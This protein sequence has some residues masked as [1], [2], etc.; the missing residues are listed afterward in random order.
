[1]AGGEFA[2]G[3]P[4]RTRKNRGPPPG[5]SLANARRSRQV[6]R[7]DVAEREGNEGYPNGRSTH[8]NARSRRQWRKQRHCVRYG[9][10]TDETHESRLGANRGEHAHAAPRGSARDRGPQRGVLCPRRGACS[11][12]CAASSAPCR[13]ASTDAAPDP[14]RECDGDA[15]DDR[16]RN[17]DCR[18]KAA[19]SHAGPRLRPCPNRTRSHASPGLWDRSARRDEVRREQRRQSACGWREQGRGWPRAPESDPET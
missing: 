7:C 18:S 8:R 14:R 2:A 1:M 12:Q 16:R 15:D 3:R 11:R 19:A 10:P 9:A 4:Q 6:A 13:D 17:R 5:P